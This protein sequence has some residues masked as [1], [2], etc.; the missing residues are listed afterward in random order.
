[1]SEAETA[2][3]IGMPVS[4]DTEDIN[5]FKKILPDMFT[6]EWKCRFIKISR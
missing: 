1:M 2:D 4:L 5:A 6:G 3:R